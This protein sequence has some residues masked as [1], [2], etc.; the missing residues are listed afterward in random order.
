MN[1]KAL[2]FLV[3][4]CSV[5]A[6]SPL[7]AGQWSTQFD[8]SATFPPGSTIGGVKN[9]TF[10]LNDSG[11]TGNAAVEINPNAPSGK[12][13]R[14]YST[15]TIPATT[16]RRTALRNTFANVE[17]PFVEA[18]LSIAW[19]ANGKAPGQSASVNFGW[20]DYNLPA[21]ISYGTDNGLVISHT[22]SGTK[23]VLL[24]P[25]LLKNDYFYQFTLIFDYEARKFDIT[26]TGEDANNAPVNITLSGLNF[27]SWTPPTQNGINGI[28]LANYRGDVY[29]M[30]VESISLT[31]TT[32]PEPSTAGLAI[33]SAAAIGWLYSRRKQGT[34]HLVSS[35]KLR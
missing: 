26:V 34:Q 18:K 7:E 31:T 16:Q 20:F 23:T 3:A 10:T 33:T 15:S 22:D 12:A 30:Y 17:G 1:I 13:L 21:A 19:S 11:D 28:F 35:P 24:A 25:E 9:W 32:I 5:L 14:I 8:N 4:V 29:N 2:P 6:I 27:Q